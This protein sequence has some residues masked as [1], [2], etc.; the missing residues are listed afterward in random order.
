MMSGHEV[1]T[2]VSLRESRLIGRGHRPTCQ[3]A[4]LQARSRAHTGDR[5]KESKLTNSLHKI[6]DGRSNLVTK[7][8]IIHD[9]IAK[10]YEE[11]H[12]EIFNSIEQQRIRTTLTKVVNVI[13]QSPSEIC[14]LDFGAG[15]GNMT[16]HLLNLGLDV[17]A[18]D[19]SK[20]CLHVVKFKYGCPTILL[21]NGSTEILSGNAYDL[22]CLYSVLHHVPDYLALPYELDRICRPGGIIYIDHEN[23]SRYWENLENYKKIY[24][25]ISKIDWVKYATFSNYVHK[26]KSLASQSTQTRATSMFGQ[27]TTSSGPKLIVHLRVWGM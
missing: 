16:N 13:E 19:V 4:Y 27:T 25:R 15:T 6:L 17:T 10:N 18:A 20:E 26:M 7:N 5:M 22:V 1:V 2:L 12:R 8:A 14:A 3:A 23:S 11:V 24:K 9:K 21:E